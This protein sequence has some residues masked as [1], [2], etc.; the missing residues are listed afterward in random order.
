MTTLH[1]VTEIAAPVEQ[2]FDLSLSVDLHVQ[3]M[4]HTGERA[5]AGVT[6]GM[7]RLGDSVTWEAR[8]FG[9]KLR[10]KTAI[11][12]YQAASRF[13]DEQLRGP[14][15]HLRHVHEFTPISGGTRMVD[16][17]AHSVPVGPIGAL[18]DRLILRRYMRQL[19]VARNLEIKRVAESAML[20]QQIRGC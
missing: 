17:F 18:F 9:I 12:E 14:F 10:L 8:H 1:L 6:R 7:M 2:C 19:L 3:S 11:T 5:V 16:D 4:R 20:G 15:T 13:V